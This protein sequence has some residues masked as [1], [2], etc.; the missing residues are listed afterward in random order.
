M[1]NTNNVEAAT[2]DIEVATSTEPTILEEE[3]TRSEETNTSGLLEDAFN[4]QEI[5][6]AAT[7]VPPM[8]LHNIQYIEAYDT[9]ICGPGRN[10]PITVSLTRFTCSACGGKMGK[11]S[12]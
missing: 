10:H 1:D 4:S 12:P 5:N 6:E 7:E 11:K 9:Y 2:I 3:P 8:P